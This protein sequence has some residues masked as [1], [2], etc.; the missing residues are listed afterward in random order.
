MVYITAAVKYD[1]LN[2]L[3]LCTLSNQ[4]AYLACSLLVAAV[5]GEVLLG[6]GCSCKCYALNIIN[7]L[8]ENVLGASEY[9]ETRALSSTGNC[10]AYSLMASETLLVRVF[11]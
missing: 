8:S 9:V 11:L 2:T 1:S 5:L 6:G 7:D 3:R 10:A 4:I